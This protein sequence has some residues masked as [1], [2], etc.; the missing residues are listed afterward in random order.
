VQHQL[1]DLDISSGDGTRAEEI[2]DRLREITELEEAGRD[3]EALAQI[4]ALRERVARALQRNDHIARDQLQRALDGLAQRW[5]DLAKRAGSWLQGPE[6]HRVDELLTGIRGALAS[7]EWEAVAKGMG[8]AP[9]LIARLEVSARDAAEPAVRQGMAAIDTA[10]AELQRLDAAAMPPRF[11]LAALRAQLSARLQEGQLDAAGQ[12]VETAQAIITNALQHVRQAVTGRVRAARADCEQAQRA[13]DLAAARVLAAE[14]LTAAEAAHEAARADEAGGDLGA[15]AVAYARAA[16]GY[17]AVATRV[18]ELQAAERTAAVDELRALL[19]ASAA[20]PMPV[21]GAARRAAETLLGRLPAEHGEA[22][23]ALRGTLAELSGARDGI[24][25]FTDADG[26]RTRADAAQARA[27]ALT[28]VDHTERRHATRMSA[29]AGRLF[30]QRHWSDAATHY[31]DAA[32]AWEKI[33]RQSRELAA[34]DRCEALRD[35]AAA[36]L[37][38]LAQLGGHAAA[39][40]VTA[41]APGIES[42]RRDLAAAIERERGGA[43]DEALAQLET[44]RGQTADAERAYGAALGGGV[45]R[46]AADLSGRWRDLAARAGRLATPQRAE[47]L[48]RQ[49][50]AASAAAA[51]GEWNVARKA[52]ETATGWL[53]RTAD[54]LRAEAE[55]AVAAHLAAIEAG[56]T[57][58]RDEGA[59]PPKTADLAAL[60]TE[61]AAAI[62]AGKLAA[63]IEVGA[64]ARAAVDGALTAQRR[65]LAEQA[66]GARAAVDALLGGVDLDAAR[67]AAPQPIDEGTRARADG[68]RAERAGDHRAALAAYERATTALRGAADA[69]AAAR[70]RQVADAAGEL[71]A[72][73]QRAAEQPA[74][75]VAAARAAA[76]A[77]LRGSEGAATPAVL[78]AL[79][80]ARDGLSRALADA[81]V[82]RDAAANRQ[83]AVASQRRVS[84]L[85]LDKDERAEV[86]ALLT[87]AEQAFERRVWDD[88]RTRYGS[89]SARLDAIEATVATRIADEKERAATLDAARKDL[90]AAAAQARQEPAE[91]V[92]D[93]LHAADELL[94]AKSVELGALAGAAAALAAAVKEV[95]QYRQAAEQRSAA[96]AA[97]TRAAEKKLSARALKKPAKAL[98]EADQVFAQRQWGTAAQRFTAVAQAYGAAEQV[99][100]SAVPMWAVGGGGALLALIVAAIVFWPKPQPQPSVPPP[101]AP[102][103]IA[104]VEPSA[105]ALTLKPGASQTFSI[106][107]PQG[108]QSKDIEWTFAGEPVNAARGQTTWQYKP[109]ANAASG[110]PYQVAVKVDGGTLDSQTRT[111]R[112]EVAP[113]AAPVAEAKP[114]MVVAAE[115]APTVVVASIAKPQIAGA[116]PGGAAVELDEGAK[117]Q[118]SIQLADASG[119]NP[120]IEWLFDGKPVSDA[121]GK[122]SWQ[123]APDSKAAG[124]HDLSVKLGDGAGPKQTQRW[125]VNVGDVPLGIELTQILPPTSVDLR[126]PVG[127]TASF[128]VKAKDKDGNPLS[129]AWTVDGKAVGGNQPTLDL[130]VTS[131]DP[132]TI[133]LA[134]TNG[135]LPKPESRQWR[136]TGTKEFKPV[137]SP[138]ALTSLDFQG[139][140]LF[141]V[142]PPAG[143]SAAGMQVAWAVNGQKVS[144]SPSF[145]FK[146]DDP[147]LVTPN[148]VQI[149]LTARDAQG[150]EFKKTWPVKVLPPEPTLTVSPQPGTLELNAGQKQTFSITAPQPVGGQAFKYAFSV[151]GKPA[152]SGS[153]LELSAE[154]GKSHT[155]V[156]SIQDNFG[157]RAREQSWTLRGKGETARPT[158]VPQAVGGGDPTTMVQAWLS[159]YRGALN[160][161]NGTQICALLKL[162]SAK[163]GT[164]VA[165]LGKQEELKVGFSGISITPSGGGACASYTRTDSFKAP[166][167]QSLSKEIPVSQCFDVVGGQ[168]QLRK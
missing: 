11:D 151:D 132:Q 1:H 93:A 23:R 55:Q 60:R 158:E 58:L 114:T 67:D 27:A 16:Q 101:S 121:R 159:M 8:D 84:E 135:K 128:S 39:L 81:D 3:G 118:F 77:A 49:T 134:I 94:Q 89:A 127:Q 131:T 21:V 165:A 33:E 76:E 13:V 133:A 149:S 167:G 153:I 82:Y 74:E 112:V 38:R 152:S 109:D 35:D 22:L 122:T 100:P 28:N 45:E 116:Q 97:A 32:A 40:G 25:A 147:G 20:D 88:A 137:V 17:R 62:A 44:L 139:S 46:A 102:I 64:A 148:G 73:L 110:S 4:E 59:A 47:E 161:K 75:L 103:T 155:V 90:R 42:L 106:Q 31:A 160:E 37:E 105:A 86:A 70:Q 129:Y 63:A 10:A 126:K 98:A 79:Q 113:A 166:N 26:K 66:A 141:K 157:Q 29:E 65:T 56:L 57:E 69:L 83:S 117:Q 54:E 111:W 71:R 14:P 92:G 145:T 140:Q 19:A 24:A 91:V 144:D 99:K 124:A 41:A 72:L 138:G 50:R 164:L 125:Q 119:G 120:D 53:G 136:L 51:G 96:H 154:A 43:R 5:S 18:G 104:A 68:E 52:L 34:K 61:S 9:S 143:Q 142:D 12:E 7:G 156:A 146:A 2:E 95:P 87:G 168:A 15:A 78:T 85:G 115:P 108:R 107:L 123:Y 130:P 150:T 30:E 48:E 162:D 36:A 163:C 80:H 6:P